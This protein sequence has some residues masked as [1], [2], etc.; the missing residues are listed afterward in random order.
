MNAETRDL[1][2][3][4]GVTCDLQHAAA[5]FTWQLVEF[6]FYP[7]ISFIYPFIY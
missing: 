5:S 7:F 4:A 1:T 6:F 3:A 2:A